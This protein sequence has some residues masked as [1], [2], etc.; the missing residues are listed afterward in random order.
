MRDTLGRTWK[1]NLVTTRLECAGVV[2]TDALVVLPDKHLCGGD[3]Y[4]LDTP[5]MTF[6]RPFRICGKCGADV[7]DHTPLTRLEQRP[8][9]VRTTT[10]G[11]AR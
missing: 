9:E 2:I 4:Q 11:R 3:V 10:R 7:T 5:K 1:I 6:K 8:P